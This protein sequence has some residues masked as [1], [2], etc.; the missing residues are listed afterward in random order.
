MTNTAKTQIVLTQIATCE[1]NIKN[2]EK[3]RDELS[4]KQENVR[5]LQR[6]ERL[7]QQAADEI[8]K[9]YEIFAEESRQSVEKLTIQEFKQFVHSASEYR[10]ALSKE[11][12]LEV[13]DSNGNRALQRLSMGQSQCLSLSFITAISR[14][15][16]KNP[17]LVID[18]PFGR[19]D[20]DVH[21]TVSA[22][23]PDLT[24]QLILF[25]IPN[26]EWNE[27]TA[28]NLKSRASHIYQLEFD[29]KNR[30]STIVEQKV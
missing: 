2:Y 1:N 8:E 20:Q 4:K 12:E 28:T 18:M 14:V 10:V 25:L 26:T 11:Y 13:L 22:R 29:A 17:P 7:A 19:L 15:S 30:Q 5:K 21:D 3:E 24:N 16:E 23:L 6:R 9:I 27:T